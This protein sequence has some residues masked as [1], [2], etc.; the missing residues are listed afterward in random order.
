[1]TLGGN[2]L[3]YRMMLMILLWIP[4]S[5]LLLVIVILI[6]IVLIDIIVC[7]RLSTSIIWW[8]ILLPL[9]IIAWWICIWSITLGILLSMCWVRWQSRP[10]RHLRRRLHRTWSLWSLIWSIWALSTDLCLL[11]L[12]KELLLLFVKLLS[13]VCFWRAFLLKRILLIKISRL[14]IGI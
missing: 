8:M 1:M 4:C 7:I 9:L 5:C 12:L 10:L 6:I 14:M 11:W 13:H 3:T 2:R